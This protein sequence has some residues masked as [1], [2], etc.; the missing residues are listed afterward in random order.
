MCPWKKSIPCTFDL[1][2][3]LH[4]QKASIKYENWLHAVVPQQ[5]D[6][7]HAVLNMPNKNSRGGITGQ[8]IMVLDYES[9]KQISIVIMAF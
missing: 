4:W 1:L 2:F 9:R 3:A 6:P 7:M 5:V 8:F